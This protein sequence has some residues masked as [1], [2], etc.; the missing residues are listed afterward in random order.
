MMT[1]PEI[2]DALEYFSPN[3][4][5]QAL[6]AAS[7]QKAELA[8]ILL[9]KLEEWKGQFCDL[10]DD[11]YLHMYA[12]YLLAE[13]RETKAYPL[14]VDL[15]IEAGE[16]AE[17]LFG[18]FITE[19]LSNVLASVYDGDLTP[20]LRLID[21]AADQYVRGEGIKTLTTLYVNGQLSREDLL[22]HLEK[23]GRNC[24]AAAN[25]LDEEWDYI[26][27]CVVCECLDIHG[28]ELSG[29]ID[30][31]FDADLIDDLLV[32]HQHVQQEFAQHTVESALASLQEHKTHDLIESTIKSMEWWY[33]FKSAEE[34][35]EDEK[36][37]ADFLQELL[38]KRTAAKK[39]DIPSFSSLLSSENEEKRKANAQKKAKKKQ[40]KLSRKKNRSKK[41]R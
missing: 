41:K 35:K 36:K 18:D 37:Y 14:M 21:T 16:S 9:A 17:N 2:L 23:I 31:L 3:F 26:A 27:G 33:C 22:T 19:D 34:K 30:E 13:F 39:Q 8:P 4:P 7:E 24:L 11:D 6:E 15:M 32:S 20:L 40:Q 25:D 1:I 5:R 29:L 12:F 38:K 28:T 10:D